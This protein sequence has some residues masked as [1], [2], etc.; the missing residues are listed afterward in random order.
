[1]NQQP[2]AMARRH[3]LGELYFRC[4]PAGTIPVFL[5]E[6]GGELLGHVDEGLGKY[7]DAF[8][9]HLDDK[10]CKKLATGHFT[11]SFEYDFAD[12]TDSAIP[13]SRRRIKLTSMILTMRKGYD[14]PVS[15]SV[16][17]A[18]QGTVETT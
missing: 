7:A 4:E 15:R 8:T 16:L 2:L 9:F 3:V 18:S 1:M 10:V 13:A 14:K 6:R 5:E 12:D 11:Y 17:A